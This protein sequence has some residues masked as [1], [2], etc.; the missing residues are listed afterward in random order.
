MNQPQPVIVKGTT[1]KFRFDTSKD[2]GFVKLIVT[3]WIVELDLLFVHAEHRRKGHAKHLLRAV[4]TFANA[5]RKDIVL[6]VFNKDEHVLRFYL[7]AGFVI[8]PYEDNRLIRKYS[9][10]KTPPLD[11]AAKEFM[12]AYRQLANQSDVLNQ[13][14]DEFLRVHNRVVKGLPTITSPEVVKSMVSWY[15]SVERGLENWGKHDLQRKKRQERKLAQLKAALVLTGNVYQE[16]TDSWQPQL[17]MDNQV[18]SLV[19]S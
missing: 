18:L 1:P 13:L 2:E 12:I 3:P 8:N 17:T 14:A 5:L 10:V 6:S 15:R 19:Q 9:P 11:Y 7:Q 4:I 16:N